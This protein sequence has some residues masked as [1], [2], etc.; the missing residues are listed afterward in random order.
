M[1]IFTDHKP[2]TS[3]MSSRSSQYKERE[4]RQLDFLS[5]CDL[6]CRRV[7]GADVMADALSR[8]EVN[9][10]EFS[11]PSTPNPLLSTRGSINSPK[12]ALPANANLATTQTTRSVRRVLFPNRCVTYHDVEHHLLPSSTP[13]TSDLRGGLCSSRR[14]IHVSCLSYRSHYMVEIT[15]SRDILLKTGRRQYAWFEK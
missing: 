15:T 12:S 8:I 9:N 6:K 4:I 5:Q 11:I 14:D 2:L 1:I 13:P 10:L 7:R 3:A